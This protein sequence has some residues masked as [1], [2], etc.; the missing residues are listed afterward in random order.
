MS[1]VI[2]N[3][4]SQSVETLHSTGHRRS[5]IIESGKLAGQTFVATMVSAQVIDPDMP[6]GNDIRERVDLYVLRPG[7]ALERGDRITEDD[8]D[9]WK[10]G[11]REDNS[12]DVETK[13]TLIKVVQGKDV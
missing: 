12:V 2:D 4:F 3:L 10:I 8:G 11:E 6:L 1:A 13:Y 7:P 5:F 9:T